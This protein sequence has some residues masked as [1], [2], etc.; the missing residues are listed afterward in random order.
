M[1]FEGEAR[2]EVARILKE[3]AREGLPHPRNLDAAI[4][5]IY[6]AVRGS[7]EPVMKVE[8]V[9][10]GEFYYAEGHDRTDATEMFGTAIVVQKGRLLL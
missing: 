6:E 4:D 7:G 1:A 2:D 9:D 3:V 5:A 10:A 8:D